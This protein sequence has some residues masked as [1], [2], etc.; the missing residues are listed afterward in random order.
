M[1]ITGRAVEVLWWREDGT[2]TVGSGFLAADRRVLTAAHN[3]CDGGVVAGEISVRLLNHAEVPAEVLYAD[4]GH[5]LAL[6]GTAE[7]PG[8]AG[9]T[10]IRFARVDRSLAHAIEECWAI[11]FPRWR[12]T[13]QLGRTVPLRDTSHIGGV[14]PTGSHLRSELLE[15]RSTST[16]EQVKGRGESAWEGM[17]GAVVFG[18]DVLGDPVAVG[19][20]IEHR[21]SE[22]SST[23]TLS[24]LTRLADVAGDV[25]P[26]WHSDPQ[27]WAVLP[28][29]AVPRAVSRHQDLRRPLADFTGRERLIAEAGERVTRRLADTVPVL[30][31]YGMAG[32]GKTELA[33]QLA[34]RLGPVFPHARIMVE[35]GRSEAW[36]VSAD[37]AMIRILRGFGMD[38][39]DLP[40]DREGRKKTLQEFLRDG[41]SLLVL[42]NVTN[43]KQILPLLPQSPGSAA[44]LTSRSAL[45][46]DG[47]SRLAVDQLPAATG[48][49]MFEQIVGAGRVARESDT[50][51]TILSML[52]GL[53]LAIRMA[54]E[55]VSSPAL[56]KRPLSS[57]VAL[58]AD[59]RTRISQLAG[60]D[61]GVRNSFAVSYN[62]LPEDTRRLFRLLGLLP[63][64]GFGAELVARAAG[65][66]VADAERLLGELVD[67]QLLQS[68][69]RDGDRY[70]LH[71]LL[72][73]YAREN[74]EQT[75]SP[76]DRHA[77]LRR[78]VEWHADR[79]HGWMSLPGAHERPPDEAIA[80]FAEEDANVHAAVRAAYDAGDWDLV[81]RVAGSLYGLLFHRSHWEGMEEVKDMAVT[82]ARQAEDERA[83]LGSL[84]HLA[85]ARRILGRGAD[86]PRLYDRAL[87]IARALGDDGVAG[88]VL[89]HYGDLQL[90]LGRPEDA[91]GRYAEAGDIY[92]RQG[93]ESALIWLSAHVA[94]AYVQA[95]R[96]ADA[97]RV[98]EEALGM[99]RRR[100][101]DRAG[102]VWC[103]WHLALAYD[104]A[105]RH[106][107]A[108]EIMTGPLAFHREVGDRA[109]LATMLTILGDIHVHSGSPAEAREAL[110]EALDLVRAIGIPRREEEIQ[111]ALDRIP[112]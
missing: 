1:D 59:E 25:G 30:V 81:L 7:I 50:A 5:D 10:P 64:V 42:D 4:A 74:A 46:I 104:Q 49:R 55:K 105:G 2:W 47:A 112:S 91:L 86:T 35:L 26:W 13:E 39:G 78:S 87:E 82:A 111:A 72:R 79:L 77:V 60:K 6:L 3:V 34:H 48:L 32:I 20:V 95:G 40:P 54:G 23:L 75:D 11:G 90:D 12:E 9:L 44:I 69:G 107:D 92:R 62:G 71:D 100:H 76:A 24:P 99:S 52:D 83:E 67:L 58:L 51:R 70:R 68:A 37:A 101:D 8:L 15:L 16:P 109:G 31:L 73:L 29:R 53:P 102:V 63:G 93:D 88:W 17:S 106:H 80:W 96:P 108:E 110:T 28:G 36:E 98:L 38:V 43:E 97:V 14:I 94:D 84:V 33:I 66:D 21:L 45:S 22:G 18:R 103:E 61:R 85:E 27:T 65:L 89:T 19:V 41:P 56:E 57:Y